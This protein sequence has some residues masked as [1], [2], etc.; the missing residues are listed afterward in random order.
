MK[1][2]KSIIAVMLIVLLCGANIYA[3]EIV[4]SLQQKPQGRQPKKGMVLPDLTEEQQSEMKRLRT[5]HLK[6]QLPMKNQLRE[7]QAELQT[8][9]TA[10]NVNMNAIEQTIEEMG[11]LRVQMAKAQATHRQTIRSLL[12]EEQR[13]VF[14]S[15]PRHRGRRSRR[16]G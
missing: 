11:S 12:T 7:L 4:D 13:V 1:T 14:D 2:S 9:S 10:E 15:R 6:S 5:E 3:E 16:R 8:L